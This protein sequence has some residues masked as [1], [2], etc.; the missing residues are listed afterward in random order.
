MSSNSCP[1]Q[2]LL[3]SPW[4]FLQ[5]LGH[6][7]NLNKYKILKSFLFISS[8]NNGVIIEIKSKRKYTKTWILKNMLLND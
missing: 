7:A 2:I 6:K 8:D 1:K 5:S 4:N 3:G